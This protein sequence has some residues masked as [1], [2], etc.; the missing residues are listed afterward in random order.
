MPLRRPRGEDSGRDSAGYM[1]G[2]TSSVPERLESHKPSPKKGVHI[3]WLDK[4]GPDNL[5]REKERRNGGRQP[6]LFA[7]PGGASLISS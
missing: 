1:L 5:T 4:R 6:P 3:S 2:M 7:V